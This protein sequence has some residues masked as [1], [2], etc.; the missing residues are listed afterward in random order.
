MSDSKGGL[1]AQAQVLQLSLS[2]EY[3]PPAQLLQLSLR[4]GG[5]LLRHVLAPS[6]QQ[7]AK[8]ANM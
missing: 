1:P 7:L 8:L 2:G 3:G 4:G 5:L 6:R